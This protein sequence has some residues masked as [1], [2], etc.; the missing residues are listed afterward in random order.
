MRKKGVSDVHVQRPA[1]AATGQGG[2]AKRGPQDLGQPAARHANNRPAKVEPRGK[3]EG[4]V[5]HVPLR[6]RPP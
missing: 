1:A 4:K 3:P 6:P 5:Q 2:D